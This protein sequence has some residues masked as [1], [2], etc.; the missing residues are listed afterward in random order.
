[1]QRMNMLTQLFFIFSMMI[2]FVLIKLSFIFFDSNDN[3]RIDRWKDAD[4]FVLNNETHRLASCN[5]PEFFK[6][7]CSKE[8]EIAISAKIHVESITKSNNIKLQPELNQKHAHVKGKYGRYI[9]DVLVG[10][11]EINLCDILINGEPKMAVK[12]GIKYDWCEN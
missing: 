8:K 11:E 1:M 3:L 5:A 2:I 4:T 9:T 12:Q 7:K 6:P 10:D